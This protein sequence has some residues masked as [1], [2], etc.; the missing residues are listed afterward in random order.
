MLAGLAGVNSK[1]SLD[2][3]IIISERQMLRGELIE[4]FNIMR[5]IDKVD[6]F[7]NG[8]NVKGHQA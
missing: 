1:E 4:V 7:P 3:W 6:F 8:G 2:K 5:G